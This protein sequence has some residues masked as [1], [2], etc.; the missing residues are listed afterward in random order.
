MKLKCLDV[1]GQGIYSILTYLC[2]QDPRWEVRLL[3][4]VRT[5]PYGLTMTKYMD[6]EIRH[7]VLCI[8]NGTVRF[9][10]N[11][12]VAICRQ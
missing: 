4:D 12:L 6:G 8:P 3:Q 2:A 11:D 1:H 10:L 5:S 7:V 9:E